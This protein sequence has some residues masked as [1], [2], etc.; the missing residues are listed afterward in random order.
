MY[1]LKKEQHLMSGKHFT[2]WFNS[3]ILKNLI[4]KENNEVIKN[5]MLNELHLAVYS[6]QPNIVHSTYNMFT[7]LQYLL[8]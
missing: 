6:I 8:V 7:E 2:Y 1:A 4:Q 3:L 5:N